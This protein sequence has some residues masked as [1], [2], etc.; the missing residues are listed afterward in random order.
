MAY[1][2]W[3]PGRTC[4][5]NDPKSL[6]LGFGV[7][8][9]WKTMKNYECWSNSGP[10]WL[11]FKALSDPPGKL[12]DITSWRILNTLLLSESWD[13]SA[14]CGICFIWENKCSCRKLGYAWICVNFPSSGKC[15]KNQAPMSSSWAV[16]F[17]RGIDG[18]GHKVSRGFVTINHFLRVN[19]SSLIK[20]FP[21]TEKFSLI[22]IFISSPPPPPKKSYRVKSIMSTPD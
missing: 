11:E 7:S 10:L 20:I 2:G 21:L 13:Q 1:A 19:P 4:R 15:K 17:S 22:K 3:T 8:T 12:C 9:C 18:S 5:Q 6:P 14:S 16:Q